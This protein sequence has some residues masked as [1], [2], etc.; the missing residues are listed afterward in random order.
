ME[1]RWAE[2]LTCVATAGFLPYEIYELSK[3]ISAFKLIALIVNLVVLVYLIWAKRL[4]G[5]RRFHPGPSDDE[6]PGPLQLFGRD[7]PSAAAAPPS[8]GEPASVR[9]VRT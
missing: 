5:L 4:F 7:P 1:R 6:Q 2:Y 8:P 3:G 9:P